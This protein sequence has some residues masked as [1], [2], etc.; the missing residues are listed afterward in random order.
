MYIYIYF[1][2]ATVLLL[3]LYAF[4]C[5]YLS[6]L[7]P[8]MLLEKLSRQNKYQSLDSQGVFRTG[9]PWERQNSVS[10]SSKYMFKIGQLKSSR[11]DYLSQGTSEGI[12]KL[13]QAGQL[14]FRQLYWG[15]RGKPFILPE[16]R[17]VSLKSH[18][19]KHYSNVWLKKCLCLR[20]FKMEGKCCFGKQ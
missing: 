13:I 19:D 18:N 5:L 16:R 1:P 11:G 2:T 14:T 9:E 15:E 10:S 8:K 3:A 20:I 12:R 6:T 7:L 17:Q 4:M